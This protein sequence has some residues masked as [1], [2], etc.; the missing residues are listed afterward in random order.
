MF[1]FIPIPRRDGEC[2]AGGAEARN[3]LLE[4]LPFPLIG[5]R[6]RPRTTADRNDKNPQIA[7]T[8]DSGRLRSSGI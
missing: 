2:L 8:G 4:K 1:S 6:L 5:G 3:G 7:D